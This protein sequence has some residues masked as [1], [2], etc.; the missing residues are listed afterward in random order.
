MG[1]T[2]PH[3][4]FALVKSEEF[5]QKKYLTAPVYELMYVWNIFSFAGQGNYLTLIENDLDKQII[6]K[7]ASKDLEQMDE[8]CLLLLLKSYALRNRF[9]YRGAIDCIRQIFKH[10]D[11]IVNYS[12]IAPNALCDLGVC[13]FLAD[14]LSEAKKYLHSARADYT[15]KRLLLKSHFKCFQ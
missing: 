11:R 1:K 8:L 12:Y 2:I 7:R 15:G 9:D 4:K 6:I 13:Y 3:E 5:L 10:E 14:E